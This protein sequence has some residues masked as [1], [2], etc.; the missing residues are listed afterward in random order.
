MSAAGHDQFSGE[1]SA[2]VATLDRGDGPCSAVASR[3]RKNLPS[4]SPTER[5]IWMPPS[6]SAPPIPG[7]KSEP[8]P[9]NIPC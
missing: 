8:F 6:C 3:A 5:T 1:R 7:C 4:G 2:P 9:A